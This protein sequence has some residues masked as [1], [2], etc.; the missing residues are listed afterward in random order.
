MTLQGIVQQGQ[1]QLTG[2][3]DLPDG[4]RVFIVT[5]A[6]PLLAETVAQRRATRWLVEFVSMMLMASEARLLEVDDRPVWQFSV[7]ITGRGHVP[8]GPIGYVQVDAYRG[9]ILADESKAEQ[10][11]TDAETFIR[12]LQSSAG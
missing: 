8:Y 11:I 9:T 7:F 6:P 5:D 12:T 3:V 10:L 2:P 4:S 1:I